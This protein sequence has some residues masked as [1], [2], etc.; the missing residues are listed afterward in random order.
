MI[1][2]VS[3]KDKKEKDLID[4]VKNKD[5]SYYI[6][7]LIKEDMKRNNLEQTKP[8]ENKNKRNVDFDL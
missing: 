2:A 1:K 8:V 5:F 7:G 4:Y 6:K 3:F